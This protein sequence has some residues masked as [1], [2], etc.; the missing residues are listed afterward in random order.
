[1]T[2]STSQHFSVVSI[3]SVATWSESVWLS[4]AE[5]TALFL[6]GIDMC[7]IRDVLPCFRQYNSFD[8]GY[9][10]LLTEYFSDYHIKIQA[11]SCS[12]VHIF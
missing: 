9:P 2:A 8:T 7:D 5:D 1:M 12:C 3:V 4:S 6:C 11:G 10:V